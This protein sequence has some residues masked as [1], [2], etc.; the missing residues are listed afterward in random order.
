MN[1]HPTPPPGQSPQDG[2][3]GRQPPPGFRRIAV[4]FPL[5]RPRL[6]FILL[7]INLLIFMYYFSLPR[8]E[9]IEFLLEW[10]KV[11]EFIVDG[12]YYRLFTSMFLHLD[13]THML[14]NGFALYIFGRDVEALFGTPRFA[15]IY[16]L[17]GLSG[18]LASFVFTDGVS[19]GASGA[20]FA[21]F[22][23]ELVYLYHHRELHGKNGQRLFS[24][25]ILFM[26]LELAIGFIGSTG[27]GNFRIDNAGHIGGL[28][29]GV[30]LAWFIGP[31]YSIR[32]DPVVENQLRVVDENPFERWA[33]SGFLYA[34]GLVAIMVFAISS[35]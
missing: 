22:G 2:E 7:G 4:S 13:L 28:V 19:V 23:A 25:L 6:M 30:V 5:T 9:Q 16:F 21:I 34:V 24:R 3:P 33:L 35:A 10:G 12:E 27:I 8:L 29:G 17:G 26:M 32:R 31:A 15:I 14:L 20:I 11:N 18:S 1:E